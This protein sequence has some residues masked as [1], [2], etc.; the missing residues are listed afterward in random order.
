MSNGNTGLASLLIR[1]RGGALQDHLESEQLPA[2]PGVL[3]DLTLDL[4]GTR[5]LDDQPQQL[6][7]IP[8]ALCFARS[9]S[10]SGTA[11]AAHPRTVAVRAMPQQ[12]DSQT[13]TLAPPS[14]QKARRQICKA[15]GYP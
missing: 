7:I 5:L 9:W 11:A 3:V 4:V 13:P 1:R 10:P 14:R 12:R 8:H 15:R 2:F 6:V